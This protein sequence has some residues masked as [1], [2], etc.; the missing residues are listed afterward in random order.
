MHKKTLTMESLLNNGVCIR[1]VAVLKETPA[2]VLSCGFCD[3]FKKIYFAE[4]LLMTASVFLLVL[5][6]METGLCT[7]LDV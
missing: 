1:A 4:H 7:V 2:Q 3:I 6:F 5:I